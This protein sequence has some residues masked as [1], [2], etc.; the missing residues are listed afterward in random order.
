MSWKNIFQFLSGDLQGRLPKICLATFPW[1]FVFKVLSVKY[2]MAYHFTG[3]DGPIN[4]IWLWYTRELPGVALV[5]ISNG[6]IFTGKGNTHLKW[7]IEVAHV[8]EKNIWMMN[9]FLW[10]SILASAKDFSYS[11]HLEWMSLT[12]GVITQRQRHK[13]KIRKHVVLPNDPL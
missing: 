13:S 5:N 8:E 1:L 7:N 9:N 4:N 10:N 3:P 11:F 2:F 12:F 6:W